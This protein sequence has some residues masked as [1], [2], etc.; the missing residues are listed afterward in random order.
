MTILYIHGLNGSLS[1]EKRIILEQYGNIIS[2]SIDYHNIPNAIKWLYD[3]Y[4]N[5]NID[6]IIGSSMG[7]FTGFHLC[8]L[9]QIPAL[10]FNPALAARSV[11]QQIPITPSNNGNT[12]SI[13]LG[14]KD[15]A[16]DPKGTLNYIGNHLST[17]QPIDIEISPALEHRIPLEVFKEAVDLFMKR[18]I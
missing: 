13:V 15:T 6:V 1:V 2:P 14:A 12:I 3:S 4:K 9:M 10:L 11:E 18:L 16:V 5:K 17:E 7:G 8:K